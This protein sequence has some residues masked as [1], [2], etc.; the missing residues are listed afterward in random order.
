MNS[1]C[2][3]RHRNAYEYRLIPVQMPIRCLTM[4]NAMTSSHIFTVTL[5][6]THATHAECTASACTHTRVALCCRRHERCERC[7]AFNLFA[8]L[9]FHDYLLL[10]SLCWLP[11]IDYWELSS[12]WAACNSVGRLACSYPSILAWIMLICSF[13][14]KSAKSTSA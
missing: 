4:T 11:Q 3:Q 8:Y 12:V 10:F 13:R 2:S 14:A 9:F 5:P 1:K 6:H 7:A